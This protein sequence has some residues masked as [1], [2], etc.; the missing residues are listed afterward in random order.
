MKQL[1]CTEKLKNITATNIVH[2]G[3]STPP[4]SQFQNH[5]PLLGSLHF[6]KS[7][8]TLGKSVNQSSRVFLVNRNATVKLSSINTVHVKQQH[9]IGFFI[10]KF[11]LKYMLGFNVY[12]NKIHAEQCL[13]IISLYC[14]EGFS[15]PFNFFVVFKGILQV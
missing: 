9:N 6:L 4:P 1:K 7:P 10:F 12:T 2:K 8:I 5:L 3:V 15:H 13:Y 11:T 14:R